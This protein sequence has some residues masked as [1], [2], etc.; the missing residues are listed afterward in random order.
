MLGP[1]GVNFDNDD[2]PVPD[3]IDFA[4]DPVLDMD[5]TVR[6][7]RVRR[8][9]I[10]RLTWHVQAHIKNFLR[11]SAARD[12]ARFAQLVEQL[13]AEEMALVRSVLAE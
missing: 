13:N 10:D 7:P 9:R 1:R 3:E 8:G 4:G 2:E 5:M 12:Q 6:P 11:E